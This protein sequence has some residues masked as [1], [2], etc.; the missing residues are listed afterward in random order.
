M[1]KYTPSLLR[2]FTTCAAFP[3]QKVAL[4][5]SNYEMVKSFLAQLNDLQGT[6]PKMTIQ[7]LTGEVW[8]DNGSVL[9][10]KAPNGIQGIELHEVV[11]DEQDSITYELK[12]HLK[13]RE[14]L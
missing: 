11:F 6:Y 5:C 12:Q 10:I 14:R 9:H 4:F 2:A 13:T 8:F 1:T 3:M 7:Y